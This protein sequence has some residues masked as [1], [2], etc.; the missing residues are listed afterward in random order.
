MLDATANPKLL[1]KVFEGIE[2]RYIQPSLEWP[3]NVYVK[4]W[5]DS[6]VSQREL[7]L[8]E[9]EDSARPAS[10][11]LTQWLDHIRSELHGLRRTLR[12]GV[13]THKS[14]KPM[15]IERVKSWGFK[16][17][18]GLHFYDL[19]GSNKFVDYH[20]L[21]IL[22]C[23]IPNI[24]DF[25]EECQ[26]FFHDDPTPLDFRRKNKKMGLEMRDDRTYPVSVYGYW[27]P[28]VSDYYQQK[29]QSE[30]YQALHRLRPNID[31]RYKRH[32]FIYTNMPIPGVKVD[33][34][35]NDQGKNRNWLAAQV[36]R[37]Q[38]AASG[39]CTVQELIPSAKDKGAED[40]TVEQYI[41]RNSEAIVILAGAWYVK[42][43]R[44]RGEEAS[45]FVSRPP[46]TGNS[47]T[48]RVSH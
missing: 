20:V 18:T 23:P 33:E 35:T 27:N 4:Q 30:L 16:T 38:I 7:G 26:A 39:E 24:N 10:T 6:S 22:G 25:D 1:R 31:R 40:R 15:V 12:V 32:V 9:F 28:P 21:L 11:K 36:V 43:K 29:C 41:R 19:R 3:P 17:V 5:G 2:Q 34:I 48:P 47:L 46:E 8:N 13:I 44:G 14:I 45:R 42:G 37:T